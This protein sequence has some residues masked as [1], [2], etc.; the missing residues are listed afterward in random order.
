M[1]YVGID[2]WN[3]PAYLEHFG[4]DKHKYVAK[5]KINGKYRYFYSLDEYKNYLN[6]GPTT[7]DIK[8]G[9]LYGYQTK[10]RIS[11]DPKNN[12]YIHSKLSKDRKTLWKNAGETP[13]IRTKDNL[14]RPSHIN[15]GLAKRSVDDDYRV[16]LSKPRKDGGRDRYG[17]AAYANPKVSKNDK[18][19]RWAIN[20]SYKPVATTSEKKYQAAKN[21]VATGNY[22]KKPKKKVALIELKNGCK[23]FLIGK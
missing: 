15:T 3:G 10:K 11:L 23:D 7:D 22:I 17:R 20:S 8:E 12:V 14:G 5:E 16:A 18:D 4:N 1:K 13:D 19:P 6:G 2:R 9:G 21:R